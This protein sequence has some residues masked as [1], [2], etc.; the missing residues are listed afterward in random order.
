MFVQQ[1]ADTCFWVWNLSGDFAIFSSPLDVFI[2]HRVSTAAFGILVSME[3]G[4]P[5]TDYP[6]THT[7]TIHHVWFSSRDLLAALGGNMRLEGQKQKSWA[8][9]SFF[10]YFTVTAILTEMLSHAGHL[11]FFF[12]SVKIFRTTVG[13][14]HSF[15]C[16][17]SVTPLR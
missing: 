17:S 2:S 13:G 4:K 16:I 12:S 3:T 5:F 15:S 10:W 9:R 11:Q 7:N 1:S 6:P 14:N 8:D